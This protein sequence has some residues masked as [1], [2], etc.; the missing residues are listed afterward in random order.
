MNKQIKNAL[1]NG[2]YKDF[3][4]EIRFPHFKNLTE[5]L[6]IKF[7]YPVTFL[8]G[9]NGTNKSSILRAL[10][11][12]CSGN[13]LESYWFATGLDEVKPGQQYIFKYIT[14]SGLEVESLQVYKGNSTK[15]D[16]SQDYWESDR[17][18]RKFNMKLMKDYGDNIPKSDSNY[19]S[20]RWKKLKRDIVY[21]DF[22]GELPAFDILMNFNW[23][24]SKRTDIRKKKNL[25]RLRSKILEEVFD[26]K[27][28]VTKKEIKG[29][30][31]ILSEVIEIPHE[32]VETIGRILGRSY[33]RI[34]LVKHDLFDA[35]G[36]TAQ[37][38]HDKITYSEAF[39]GSGEFAA[40]M[41]IFA[42][43][44]A[45]PYSLILLDE[46]ETS[47]HPG[48]QKE[49]IKY[50]QKK[51]LEK[52]LQFVI[53]THSP[54][55]IEEF[56]AESIKAFQYDQITSKVLLPSQ[57]SHY[58]EAFIR[59]GATFKSEK[60]KFVVEDNLALAFINA[61]IKDLPSYKK[62]TIGIDVIPG[63]ADT[64]RK[65]VGFLSVQKNN[66]IHFYL[67]GDQK[68]E[69]RIPNHDLDKLSQSQIEDAFKLTKVRID[70][71]PSNSGV[72]NTG[73]FDQKKI[74][75][76]WYRRNVSYLPTSKDPDTL[77]AVLDQ[78]EDENYLD[79]IVDKKYGK[80]YW[81]KKAENHFGELAGSINSEMIHV[82]QI[83]SLKSIIN[84]TNEFPQKIL[85]EIKENI[86][87]IID[88][89]AVAL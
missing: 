47:L 4:H 75:I 11:C 87:K 51:S 57:A 41:L 30:E 58:S 77:L 17:P 89:N 61:A 32:G 18:R 69:R 55:L 10:Q 71:I 9:P 85:R 33:S 54:S 84:S 56:P 14:P 38:F 24:S 16:R 50:I 40:I 70:S 15:I 8:T 65:Y 12:T 1:S 3:I 44:N 35:E 67:D 49:L 64:I 45:S 43:S 26:E 28:K 81:Q 76:D 48:A 59:M 37:L 74:V 31:R 63:G 53:A 23:H 86:E 21:L 83:Q 42:I 82:L 6:S 78:N 80:N 52:K 39:A 7:D 73:R 13:V 68:P 46:P 36:Y 34:K 66:N 62:D 19:Y 88:Q 25:I 5:N 60:L 22:R 79:S 2:E 20:D 27:N 29:I 72:T